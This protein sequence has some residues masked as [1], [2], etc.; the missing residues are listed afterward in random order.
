MHLVPFWNERR[1]S[2]VPWCSVNSRRAEGGLPR[3][4]GIEAEDSQRAD[5]FFAFVLKVR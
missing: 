3:C 2:N 1:V 4:A 5:W